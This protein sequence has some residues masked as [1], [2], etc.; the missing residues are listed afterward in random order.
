M[1]EKE[2]PVAR[3]LDEFAD[4]LLLAALRS[5][6]VPFVQDYERSFSRLLHQPGNAFVL[7]GNAGRKIDNQHTEV[8]ASNTSLGAHDTENFHRTGMLPAPTHS[9]RVDENKIPAVALARDIDGIARGSGEFA[10]D[11]AVAT[12]NRVNKRRFSDI[13]ASNCRDSERIFGP[14]RTRIPRRTGI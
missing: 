6:Q 8:G 13:R 10:H 12:E 7:G 3:F 14:S 4:R 9:R 5:D 1:I 11:R 2:K